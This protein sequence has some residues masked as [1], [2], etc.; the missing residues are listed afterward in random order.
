[1]LS[2]LPLS[3]LI[4]QIDYSRDVLGS[5]PPFTAL[6]NKSNVRLIKQARRFKIFMRKL[7]TNVQVQTVIGSTRAGVYN[8]IEFNKWQE[9]SSPSVNHFGVCGRVQQWFYCCILQ[10]GSNFLY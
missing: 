6:I 5:S 1:M 2:G 10:C 3:I 9:S 7:A 4:Y 8:Q